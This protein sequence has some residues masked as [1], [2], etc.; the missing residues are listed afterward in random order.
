MH[1][2]I[3]DSLSCTLTQIS[4]LV[5]NLNKKNFPQSSR[6]ISEV[7]CALIPHSS[8]TSGGVDGANFQYGEEKNVSRSLSLPRPLAYSFEPFEDIL[9]FAM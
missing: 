9:K 1:N 2:I 6:E 8:L 5:F 7:S 4:Y 3:S